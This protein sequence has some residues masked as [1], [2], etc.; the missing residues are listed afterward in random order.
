MQLYTILWTAALH[1]SRQQV[2]KPH[3]CML[4][5]LCTGVVWMWHVLQWQCS[6]PSPDHQSLRLSCVSCHT[7]A[8]VRGV[9]AATAAQPCFNKRAACRWGLTGSPVTNTSIPGTHTLPGTSLQASWAHGVACLPMGSQP[10]PGRPS[11]ETA[12]SPQSVLSAMTAK[13][14]SVHGCGMKGW[15]ALHHTT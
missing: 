14:R 11:S 13:P 7:P 15:T 8:A 10:A 2:C 6:T 3:A 1:D 12:A 9:A 4:V 5:Q